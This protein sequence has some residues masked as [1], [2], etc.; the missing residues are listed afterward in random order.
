MTNQ[1]TLKSTWVLLFSILIVALCG[2]AYELI[3]AAVS[4]YLL[5]NSVYQFSITIG[6]F[7]FAM[8]IGSFLS[9]WVEHDLIGRFILIEVVISFIGGL[10]SLSLFVTF[11]ELNAFYSIMMYG[12]IIVIGTLVG[13]EIPILTRILS[14]KTNIKDNIA[15]V[16]SLD[17]VGALF[18]SV[19]FPLLLLPTLGL[20]RSSFAVGLMNILV[21]IIN[22]LIFKKFVRYPRQLLIGA[23]LTLFMLIGLTIFGTQLTRYAE[24]H[25]YFDQVIYEEQT[26][27]QRII[28]TESL[29]RG[30]LR[31]YIDGHIQFSARDEYRY[32]EALVH[33]VMSLPGN[34]DRVLILGGGDGLAAREVLKYDDVKQ[35]DLVDIDPA[36]TKMARRFA[37]MTR[38]NENSLEDPKLTIHHVDAFTFIN[39]PGEPYDRVI[40]DMPDPHNEAL[41]KLYSREFYY[42]IKRRMDV[43]GVLVTQSSSPFFTRRTF[44]SIH[45]TLSSIFD[46]THSYHI[47]IPAFGIWGFN[48]A[49]VSQPIPEKFQI[50]AVTRFLD[51]GVMQAAGV[52]GKDIQPLEVPINSIMEPKLYTLYLQDLED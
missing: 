41:N 12:F 15:N 32:H 2:I 36:I 42:M 35:I 24:H 3:I 25:L 4:S 14:E 49:T 51:D 8:G 23:I 16:L 1:N 17:Y 7:M 22:I 19:M 46:Q 21:A 30:E 43:D 34:R 52:F 45:K 28:F 31:L 44:W 5:G 10:C 48:L 9:R 11:A 50:D 38:L 6:V 27:Y 18:G 33:P 20:I 40:I 47:T 13:L 39:N 29:K 37:G 26:P